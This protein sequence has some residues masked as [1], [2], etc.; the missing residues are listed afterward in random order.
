MRPAGGSRGAGTNRSE[1]A[2]GGRRWDTP[3]TDEKAS[4]AEQRELREQAVDLIGLCLDWF[5]DLRRPPD[6]WER[7]HLAIAISLLRAGAYTLAIF[8]VQLAATRPEVRN[9]AVITAVDPVIRALDLV[10]LRAGFADAAV[11]PLKE[12][13][14]LPPFSF[15]GRQ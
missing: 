1:R 10:A 2:L 14:E 5:D 13:P 9:P 12:I 6:A 7:A 15:K 4:V 3:K 8:E 11:T